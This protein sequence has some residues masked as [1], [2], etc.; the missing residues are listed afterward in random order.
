MDGTSEK[1]LAGPRLAFD[2][3]RRQSARVLLSGQEP[4]G[5]VTNRLDARAVAEQIRQ[6]FHGPRILLAGQYGVQLLTS[7]HSSDA[8]SQP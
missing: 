3:H 2:Q 7:A 8:G 6:V 4:R 1:A 5:A